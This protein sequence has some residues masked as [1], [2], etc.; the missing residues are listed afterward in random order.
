M[1]NRIPFLFL[2]LLCLGALSAPQRASAEPPEARHLEAELLA[3]PSAIAPGGAF[4]AG[5][6][7]KLEPHWHVYWKNPG[8]AGL[9]VSLEWTLPEG[10][11]AGSIQWPHPERIEVPPLMNFGYAGEVLLPVQITTPAALP[12]GM[13]KLKAKA[14]WVVCNEICL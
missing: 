11:K 2:S 1:R 6:H 8:D 5:L 13:V 12:A 7:L 10:F 4:W 9:P 14:K 3:E